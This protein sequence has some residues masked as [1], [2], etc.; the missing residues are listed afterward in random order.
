MK[1]INVQEGTKM[2]RDFLQGQGVIRQG[3]SN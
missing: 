2:E 1:K 3:S